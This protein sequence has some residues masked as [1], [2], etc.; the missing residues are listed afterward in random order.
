MSAARSYQPSGARCSPFSTRVNVQGRTPRRSASQSRRKRCRASSL[1]S[2]VSALQLAIRSYSSSVPTTMQDP[3]ARKHKLRYSEH[4]SLMVEH[5]RTFAEFITELLASRGLSQRQAAIRLGVSES[6]VS[7]WR[8]GYGGVSMDSVDKIATTFGVDREYLARLAGLRD[9]TPSTTEDLTD[10]V[11]SA[12]LDAEVSALRELINGVPKPFIPVILAAVRESSK[13]ARM[14]VEAAISLAQND[15]LA[16]HDSDA[17]ENDDDTNRG[18][19][20]P[21]TASLL[22]IL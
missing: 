14:N 2:G 3:L 21:L 6:Q 12:Q 9:N 4:T 16:D 18:P 1:V 17:A 22:A 19:T 7:R 20:G 13:L 15:E 10:P 5:G 8:Q 11:I